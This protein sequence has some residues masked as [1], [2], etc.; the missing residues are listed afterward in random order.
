MRKLLS[1]YLIVILLSI[2]SSL[3]ARGGTFRVAT[4]GQKVSNVTSWPKGLEAFLNHPSRTDGWND[5][6]TEWPNDVEHYQFEVKDTEE[7]NAVLAKFANVKSDK[8]RVRLSPG[9]EPRSIGWVSE[10]K[11][12]NKT[13]MLFTTGDQERLD[14]WFEQLDGG[15]F[16]TMEFAKAP[17]AVPPTLTIFVENDAIDLDKLIIP[18]SIQVEAGSTPGLFDVGNL[19]V[20]PAKPAPEPKS[21]ELDEEMKQVME[22]IDGYIAKRRKAS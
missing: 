7:A 8:L 14:E 17:T 1:A 12:G 13:A 21:I 18:P 11:A 16:G 6:F 3:H 4:K 5:W 20:D 19:K 10:I 9:K 2:C 15:K 22:Q